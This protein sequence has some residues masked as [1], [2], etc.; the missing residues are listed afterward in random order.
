M[1]LFVSSILF[2][3]SCRKDSFITSKDA[4]IRLS[5]DTLYFDTVFTTAGSITQPVK[6]IN[7]NNQKLLLSSV[8]LMGGSGS[9]FSINIDGVGAVERDNIELAAGDSLYVFVAVRINPT[10]ATLPFVIQD[11]I[12]VDFNGKQQFIQLQAYGQNAI[13]LRNQVISSNTIWS[14]SLPYV[15]LGS[16]EVG[17]GAR[18]TIPAGC[19]VYF[20]A[21]A[22]LL[23]DGSLQVLGDRYDSTRVY[24][25]GDRPDDPYRSFPASWPGIY[26]RG[27]STNNHLQYAVLKNAYQAIVSQSP[28]SGSQ[29]TLVLDECIVDNSYDAGIYGIKGSIQA[30]NCLVSNCGKN[31]VLAGGGNYQFTHCTVV[32]YSNNYIAHTQPVLSVSDAVSQGIGTG[33]M[34]ADFKNCIF[35]G[36][37]GNVDN[38]VSVSKQGS[39]VFSVNFTNCLWKVKAAPSNVTVTGMVVNQDPAFDSVNNSQHFYNFHLKA[40][41]PALDKG[42]PTGL[43]VDLDGRLR[44]A[45][46]PDLGCYE[47]Q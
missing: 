11:S 36:N 21:D 19:K 7:S 28:P 47:R 35:W 38:E 22:P 4:F 23:V 8:K 42:V 46:L 3:Y 13:F 17:M 2:E 24:F 29:P 10:G 40:G 16:L 18:L 39:G 43:A 15:I 9:P 20:H 34:G 14:N 31:I 32:S 25:S 6:I 5:S 27:T 37:N 12:S 33:D 30:N 41:S 26:F 44:A 45:G 1:L